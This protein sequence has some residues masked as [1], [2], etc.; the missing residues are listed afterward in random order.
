MEGLLL[1]VEMV[2]TSYIQL[3][4][5]EIGHLVQH[6]KLFGH[7]MV[8]M[9]LEKVHRRSKFLVKIFRFVFAISLLASCYRTLKK[10]DA[11]VLSFLVTDFVV[12]TSVIFCFT[13]MS[14]S[15][16]FDVL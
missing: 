4:H 6:W 2:N 10:L 11:Q 8:N 16:L 13:H 12:S 14:S 9:L 7:L 3:W 1:F 5:G 15:Y